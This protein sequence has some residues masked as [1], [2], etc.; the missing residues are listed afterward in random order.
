MLTRILPGYLQRLVPGEAVDAK[1][2]QKVEFNKHTC[3][4]C[5]E[6]CIRVDAEPLHHSETSGNASIGHDP[7]QHVG[8]LALKLRKVPKVVMLVTESSLDR[9]RH[10]EST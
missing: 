3:P 5:V 1:L 2:G 6:K 7:K 8:Y 9:E 10:L 4:L